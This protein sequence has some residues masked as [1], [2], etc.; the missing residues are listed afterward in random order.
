MFSSSWT[1]L[2]CCQNISP[3]AKSEQAFHSSQST[4]LHSC[5]FPPLSPWFTTPYQFISNPTPRPPKP[6]TLH[7]PCT[8]ICTLFIILYRTT[9]L[10]SPSISRKPVEPPSDTSTSLSWHLHWH[11]LP[12]HGNPPLTAVG[13][14]GGGIYENSVVNQARISQIKTACWSRGEVSA[15][16]YPTVETCWVSPIHS[17]AVPL[18]WQP[19]CKYLLT[20]TRTKQCHCTS[21]WF[22]LHVTAECACSRAAHVTVCV[23]IGRR[24]IYIAP[25]FAFQ[26]IDSA[27]KWEFMYRWALLT[28]TGC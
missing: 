21:R 27:C 3:I 9:T 13:G 15:L 26:A 14:W 24:W 10:S 25:L 22:S 5:I 1:S 16:I 2:T 17:S 20:L 8:R 28:L 19:V 12:K 23:W 6:P 11:I 7:Q 4:R 18:L